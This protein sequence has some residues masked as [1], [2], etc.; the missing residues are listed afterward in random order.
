MSNSNVKKMLEQKKV[1]E[2]KVDKYNRMLAHIKEN[3]LKNKD[4]RDDIKV[5]TIKKKSLKDKIAE[6]RIK[7]KDLESK[8]NTSMKEIKDIIDK[9]ERNKAIKELK[10]A[11]SPFL[12]AKKE[13]KD[14]RAQASKLN[15]Q[16]QVFKVAYG[17]KQIKNISQE[18]A[19]NKYCV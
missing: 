4:K 17:F 14:L 11:S 12:L 6:F 1:L 2:A 16:Q 8:Y 15:T 9:A 10:K 3:K 18:Y 19:I 13:L 5:F 7:V